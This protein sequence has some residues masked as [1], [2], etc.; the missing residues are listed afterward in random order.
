MCDSLTFLEPH[1]TF[2]IVAFS[3]ELVVYQ[4]DYVPVTQDSVDIT[5][6]YLANI[7]S[8]IHTRC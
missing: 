4:D 6:N 1:D 8:Q 5:S 7:K 3:T 2:N